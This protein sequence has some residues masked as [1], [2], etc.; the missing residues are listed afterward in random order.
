MI[1]Y[2]YYRISAVEYAKTYALTR[3]SAYYNFDSLGGD[4]TNFVS[5]CVFAGSKIMNYRPITGW[6]YRGLNDRSA[7]WT[8]V[9]FFYRFLISNDGVGPFAK[10]VDKSQLEIG[11]IIGLGRANGE[12]YH[13]LIVSGFSKSGITVCAHTFDALDRLLNSYRYE[14]ARYLHILGVRK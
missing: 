2:D 9:E 4:C 5:Q 12:F 10:L 3:N 8:G 11:D 6:Y 13:T 7:S 1:V 14:R